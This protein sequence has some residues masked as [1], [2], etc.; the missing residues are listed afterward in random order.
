MAVF[1]TTIP[2]FCI[3]DLADPLNASNNSFVISIKVSTHSDIHPECFRKEI[4]RGCTELC[5]RRFACSPKPHEGEI[6]KL[7]VGH[8]DR[9]QRIAKQHFQV[10][11]YSNK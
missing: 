6:I 8:V 2:D 10:M 11:W 4:G 3:L 1:L 5:S 7:V 9:E